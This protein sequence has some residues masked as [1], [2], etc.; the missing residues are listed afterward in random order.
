MGTKTKIEELEKRPLSHWIDKGISQLPKADQERIA[1]SKRAS[2]I[3]EL[4]QLI[5][6]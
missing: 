6:E 5:G 4:K 3:A 2:E 1:R